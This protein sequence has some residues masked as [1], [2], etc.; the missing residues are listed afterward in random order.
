MTYFRWSR[1]RPTVV[2]DLISTR[3]GGTPSTYFRCRQVVVS[4]L[5]D[6]GGKLQDTPSYMTYFRWSRLRPTVV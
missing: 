4:I 1:L 5:G 6:C 2:Y 3:A